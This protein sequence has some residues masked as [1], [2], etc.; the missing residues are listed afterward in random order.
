MTTLV[1]GGTGFVGRYIIERL[2]A[3]GTPTVSY[4]RDFS[5]SAHP[6]VIAVQGELFDLPVLVRTLT[7]HNVDRI[8]HT[9]AMSHPEISTELPV[10]TFAANVDGTLKLLEAA[11]MAGTRRIVN[12]SS[13]CAY[14]NQNESELLKEDASPLPNTPYGVTKVATELLGRVYSRLYGLDVV[15]LRITEVY[16]PGLKM[17][18]I[19]RDM[20]T[21]AIRHQPFHMDS[22]GDH[23]FQFV[24][25]EDVARAAV[26]AADSKTL[27]NYVYNISGGQQ[28]TISDT[29]N[30]IR[31]RFPSADI[32]IGPGHLDGWDRQGPFD[33]TAAAE[34]L[35]Y[36]P[37]HT[38][39]EGIEEYARHLAKHEF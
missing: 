13:E 6:S 21:A 26:L 32:S 16:G 36:T 1:T 31:A 20:I 30:I 18:E 14:G 12:F 9:A 38:L 4:N 2:A 23:R 33:T 7:Q 27:H 29:A 17:P 19:L 15:S 3:K 35:S 39:S 10:T 37:E 11:R 8:I 22:G 5:V 28:V 34:D 24:H 25:A